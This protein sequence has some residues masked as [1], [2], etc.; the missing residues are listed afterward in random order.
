[1]HADSRVRK[2]AC[3]YV[4]SYF[5]GTVIL[6]IKYCNCYVYFLQLI[7]MLVRYDSEC[8]YLYY[9]IQVDMTCNIGNLFFP[10]LNGLCEPVLL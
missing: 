8:I 3:I 10:V 9:I 7:I 1:M 4:V 5:R 6:F 2:Y